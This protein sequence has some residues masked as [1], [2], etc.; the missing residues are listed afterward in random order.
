[1]RTAGSCSAGGG[2]RL[3]GV[4]SSWR[5][6]R[7]RAEA[8]RSRWRGHDGTG[9]E[10]PRRSQRRPAR[11]R[12]LHRAAVA[13]TPQATTTATP[14]SKPPPRRPAAAGATAIGVGNGAVGA[15]LTGADGMTLYIFKKDSPGRAPAR[16]TARRTGRRSSSPRRA[17]GRR[18]RRDRGADDV[19]PR[20]RLDAGRLRR[21]AALL[22]RGRHGRRRHQRPGRRR[23]LVRRRGRHPPARREGRR[24]T[25]CGRLVPPRPPSAWIGS[26]A[27]RRQ[28]ERDAMSPKTIGRPAASPGA[29]DDHAVERRSTASRPRT[30]A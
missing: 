6:A 1:M 9:R 30:R 26:V 11:R 15:F 8:P 23:R 2:R 28:Q 20:R 22:L 19:R 17:P 29:L 27:E 3:A 25:R 7:A 12:R 21:R 13:G 4:R 24:S 18:R 14:A 10:Q 5:P 16:A